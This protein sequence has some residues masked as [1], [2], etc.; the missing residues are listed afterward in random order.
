MTAGLPVIQEGFWF[1]NSK[2][3]RKTVILKKRSDRSI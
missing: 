2:N 1:E 3:V